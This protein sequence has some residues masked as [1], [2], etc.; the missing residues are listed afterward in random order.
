MDLTELR[1]LLARHARPD[2]TTAIDGVLIS[3]V[4]RPDPPAP[5]TSGT[6]LAVIAQGAKR[7]AL[8]N[9]VYEYRAGQYLVASVDLPVT[10]QFTQID[11]G[12][13]ALGFG[14]TLEPSAVAELL[15]EPDP[16]THP[17]RPGERRR[18]SSSVTPRRR[19]STRWY[20]S[21]G[22]STSP[23]TAPYWRR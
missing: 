20:G 19:C 3:R 2:W 4:D 23:G 5:S 22:C 13:P 1:T 11:P 6:V 17:A 9:R 14:L 12:R 16:E 15:L 7:L 21:C 18:A 8:G 10:G